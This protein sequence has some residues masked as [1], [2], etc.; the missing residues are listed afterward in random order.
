MK[1]YLLTFCIAFS[2]T[3][4]AQSVDAYFEKIRTNEAALTAFFSQMPKGGDLH[5]HYSG[6]VYAETYIDFV[7]EQNYWINRTTLEVKDAK[8]DGSKEWTRFSSIITDGQLADY[9]QKLFQK[10]SVKDYNQVSYP[11]D[12]LFFET[13]GYFGIAS[14]ARID[15]GLLELKKRAQTENVSYIETIFT[16]I[17]SKKYDTIGFGANNKKFKALRES[18]NSVGKPKREQRRA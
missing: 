14:K 17:D 16:T 4:K 15:K 6:S 13:F 8:P 10:W 7:V 2:I 18:K 12:K 5:H 1:N 9:K 11:S 3:S